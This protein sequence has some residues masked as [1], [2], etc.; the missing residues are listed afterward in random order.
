MVDFDRPAL[1]LLIPA[2]IL[3]QWIGTR[4]SLA[5]WP[6]RQKV[7]CA[8]LRAVILTLLALALAGPRWLTRTTEPAVVLLRDVS[9]S[10]GVETQTGTMTSWPRLSPRT[11][12]IGSPR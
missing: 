11:I 12:P 8:L 3:L 2:A 9:A 6:T 7:S 1:L 5:R 10:I 4:N